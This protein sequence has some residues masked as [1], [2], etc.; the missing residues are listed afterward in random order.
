M[1]T[2]AELMAA[3][4]GPPLRYEDIHALARELGYSA[5]SLLALAP[6][7]DPFF[8]GRPSRRRNGE[9]FARLWQDLGFRNGVH[10]RR[11]HYV[12]VS[13]TSL[14]PLPCG[15][16]YI[17]TL[18]CWKLLNRA[19]VAARYLGLVPISAFVDRRNAE[20][21]I[22]LD[23][24]FDERVDLRLVG[25][26]PWVGGDMPSLPR[27]AAECAAPSIPQRYHVEIWCEKTT[28]NDV[29]GPLARHYGAN[30]I[31]GAGEL[32]I[33]ACHA[34]VNRARLSERPVRILYVSDFDPA[35]LGMPVS[36]A[37]KIE[38]ELAESGADLDIQLRP[39][40]L[41]LEQCRQFQLPR[42]PIKESERRGRRFEERFGEGATELDALEALHPGELEQ[43]LQN[44]IERYHD[45]GLDA[46]VADAARRWEA[47]VRSTVERAN[48]AALAQHSAEIE[49][50]KA[51]WQPIAEQIKAWLARATP[52]WAAISGQLSERQ[53]TLPQPDWPE[54]DD[55]DEDSD[56]LF[57]SARDYLEQRDAYRAWQGKPSLNPGA[58]RR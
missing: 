23:H 43:I 6:D 52:L 5:E 18:E 13:Q 37:R 45:G 4:D 54:A 50:L 17:N 27:L 30:L 16:D 31:T 3:L 32:S 44:E 19:S 35:G 7:N 24:A 46:R 8:A 14:V 11:I 53:I 57:D 29:L 39:I 51:D 55:G 25:S 20:P 15:G 9:W 22:N 38:W 26:A 36:V 21:I 49:A 48:R 1:T 42:T 40:V 12:L 56:P 34:V 10:L 28:V 33:T 58:S 47:K 2:S 41:T